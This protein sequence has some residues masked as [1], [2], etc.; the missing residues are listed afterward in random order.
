MFTTKKQSLESKTKS[1]ALRTTQLTGK[2]SVPVLP[3]MSLQLVSELVSTPLLLASI[4]TKS[5]MDRA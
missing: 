3:I 1:L 4:T 2:I 5:S